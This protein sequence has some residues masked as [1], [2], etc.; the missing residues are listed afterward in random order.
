MKKEKIEKYYKEGRGDWWF[1]PLWKKIAYIVAFPFIM[2]WM[3]VCWV[4]MCVGKYIYMSG[5][6]LSGFRWNEGNWMEEV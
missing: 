1:Y 2:A 4:I 5:D 6:A 3:A